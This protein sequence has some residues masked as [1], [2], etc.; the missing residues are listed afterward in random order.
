MAGEAQLARLARHQLGARV[1]GL[2]HAD[3]EHAHQVAVD[4]DHAPHRALRNAPGP[5]HAIDAR[6]HLGP[7]R[8]RHR[9][10]VDVVEAAQSQVGGHRRPGDSMPRHRACDRR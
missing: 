10:R 6:Y 5:E 4:A 8:Q 1:A 2:A 7:V 9:L 3:D